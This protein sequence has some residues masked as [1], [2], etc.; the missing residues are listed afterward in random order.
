MTTLVIPGVNDGDK[1]LTDIA[2]FLY[3]ISPDIPWHISAFTPQ[4]KMTDIPPTPVRTLEKAYE[5]GR[6][7][8]LRYIYVGNIIDWK[9]SSTYCP[10]CH[11]LLVWRRGYEFSI[12]DFDET[13]GVCR[14]CKEKIYGIWH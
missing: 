7:A 9:R 10:K 12:K 11:S 5:I 6:N 14:N 8:G 13:K 2:Q 4:Y 1:E 3:G